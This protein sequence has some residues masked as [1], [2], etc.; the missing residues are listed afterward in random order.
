VRVSRLLL[1][2]GMAVVLMLVTDAAGAQPA[3]DYIKITPPPGMRWK[4]L[5][6][7]GIT[8]DITFVDKDGNTWLRK[9]AAAT[10]ARSFVLVQLV[11]DS[12]GT[13]QWMDLVENLPRFLGLRPDPDWSNY[14]AF[15]TDPNWRS[16]ITGQRRLAFLLAG[17]NGLAMPPSVVLPVYRSSSDSSWL[18]SSPDQGR[19]PPDAVLTGDF[20]TVR[21]VRGGLDV[22]YMVTVED[23]S[24]NPPS[25]VTRP[26]GYELYRNYYPQFNDDGSL[27]LSVAG[28]F[29]FQKDYL[30]PEGPPCAGGQPRLPDGTCGGD[31]RVRTCP[32]G[33][34]PFPDGSC[35]DPIPNPQPTLTTGTTGSGNPRGVNGLV[36][37]EPTAQPPAQLVPPAPPGSGCTA[38]SGAVLDLCG[39]AGNRAIVVAPAV[40]LPPITLHVNPVRGVVHVPDWYW[41]EGYDGSP[42]SVSRDYSLQWS[43]PGAPIIDAAT[44]QVIGQLPGRSGTYRISV[45]VRYRPSRYR[46]DLGDGTVLDTSS[47]GQAYPSISDVQHSF[48][49][50]SLLQPGQMYTYRLVID[51]QGDWQVSGDAT[52]S[53]T[54]EPRQSIASAQQEMREVEQLRCPDTGC[55][56]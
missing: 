10:F 16:L 37:P 42:R 40:P 19:F 49:R 23:F 54:V 5:D 26:G 38:L 13:D 28:D 22:P 27:T 48:D 8:G 24:T 45:T 56:P 34:P 7:S 2:V 4:T 47:L 52:G 1:I 21:R 20:V 30:L 29:S 46:W 32:N 15:T 18:W 12:G 35:G 9:S 36:A 50:S 53:G 3:P 44:G 55:I 51:W 33:M 6:Q 17:P 31:G 41:A 43:L 14:R 39:T 11:G 25:D